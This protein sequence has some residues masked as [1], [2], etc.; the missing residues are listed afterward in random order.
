LDTGAAL[1]APMAV[2]AQGPA[3]RLPRIV[4]AIAAAIVLH[5]AILVLRPGVSGVSGGQVTGPAVSVL[6]VRILRLPAAVVVASP[7]AEPVPAPSLTPAP[8]RD[9]SPVIRPTARV[10]SEA[11][12]S[13]RRMEKA[14]SRLASR[15]LPLAE[16]AVPSA[17]ALAAAPDYALGI[18]LD[19]GPKP[20]DEI[21]PDYPDTVNLRSGTVV[22]RLLISD[23]G[24]VD[25]VSVVR[26]EPEG[27]FEKAAIEAFAK[28]R[29]SPGMAGGAPVKS[30]IRV[31]VQFMPINRGGRISGRSY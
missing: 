17:P 19:P 27:V 13:D 24:H 23:T 4:A 28:A 5:A 18:K 11:A 30:Q 2:W 26:A 22:L 21:D 25:D 9:E 16:P 10:A 20:L 14:E 6:A 29:F 1:S 12:R 7:G 31:E 15:A 8:E 3:P